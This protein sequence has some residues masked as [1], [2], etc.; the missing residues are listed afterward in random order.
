MFALKTSDCL[1][2]REKKEDLAKRNLVGM[3]ISP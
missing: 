3:A 2:S 1:K